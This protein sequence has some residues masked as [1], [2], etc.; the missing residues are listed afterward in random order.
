MTKRKI[1]VFTGNRAE[2]GLL[3]PILKALDNHSELDYQLLVSGAHLDKSFG[4]TLC[5]ITAD[6]FEI[7]KEIKVDMQEGK[8]S[9]IA[10]AIGSGICAVSEAL[11]ELKPDLLIIYGDRF[12]SFSALIA[13]TQ[14]AIPTAHI[15]GGDLT[16]GG[17]LDDSVRHAMTKLSHL[18]FT[19]NQQALNRVLAMGEESWRVHNIGIPAFDSIMDGNYA[20]EEEVL[21]ELALDINRP[22]VICTQHSIAAEYQDAKQQVKPT[23]N[24]M[25]TLALSGVQVVF[26]YPNNDQGG[27]DI[28]ALLESLEAEKLT[29]IQ[30]KKSLGRY[31]YHGLLALARNPECKI[32]CV[33][34]SSSGIK[35]TPVFHCPTVNIGNRQSGR[36]RA[37]NLIEVKNYNADE[38]LATVKYALFDEEFRTI[39]QR[40]VNPYYVGNAGEKVCEILANV[41][42]DQKL[43][44]KSMTLAGE[45]KD[46]WFR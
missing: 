35:E 20:S 45:E 19:T 22:I 36:L 37:N 15:E 6:G 28:I 34:N 7:S 33:G 46:G 10:L 17:A 31:L 27:S 38:I 2:Y 29:N 14:M 4:N 32:A 9:T 24:A 1:A 8:H 40:A 25:K 16:D 39:C 18:H 23:L 12:E 21:R 3:F 13:S 43:I 11:E 42:L 26:T 44:K 41:E 5:E 30:I